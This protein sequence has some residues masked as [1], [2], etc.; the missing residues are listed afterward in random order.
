MFCRFIE[1]KE[2]YWLTGVVV[3][4]AVVVCGTSEESLCEKVIAAS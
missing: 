4:M 1:M 2:K 3:V